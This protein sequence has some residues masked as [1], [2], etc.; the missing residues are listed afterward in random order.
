MIW[1]E[2][3]SITEEANGHNGIDL[4]IEDDLILEVCGL[5]CRG[6]F[7]IEKTTGRMKGGE[8]PE[9]RLT[10]AVEPDLIVSVRPM[11]PDPFG[12]NLASA[13]LFRIRRVEKRG[14]LNFAQASAF[15]CSPKWAKPS[16]SF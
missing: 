3:N 8:F 10:A 5:D 9:L 12:E 2:R 13:A 1:Q 7:F 15:E 4:S 16:G 6:R 11:R 14:S